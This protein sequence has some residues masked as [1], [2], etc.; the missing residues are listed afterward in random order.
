MKD[1]NLMKAYESMVNKQ[2]SELKQ[3][4]LKILE[5]LSNADA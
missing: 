1:T 2:T 3:E 4:L 5:G